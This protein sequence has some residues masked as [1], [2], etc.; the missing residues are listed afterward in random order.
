[1]DLP[2]FGL[3]GPHPHRDY[4]LNA[5]TEF[6]NAF[7]LHVGVKQ[8]VITGNSWGGLLAWYYASQHPQKVNGLIL[9]D[10]AGYKMSKIPKRFLACRYILGR[11]M[12]RHTMSKWVI[13]ADLREV[14]SDPGRLNNADVTRYVDLLLRAGNRQAFLD[15]VDKRERPNLKLLQHITS[16]TLILWGRLDN[17]YSVED[18][19]A[20]QKNIPNAVIAIIENAGHV[21]ME[22]APDVCAGHI[23]EFLETLNVG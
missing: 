3:T 20:F 19:L 16:P 12:L 14:Y 21:P 8:F 4:S 6:L 23:R 22:E 13:R 17:L 18:A 5:Y 10:A 7:A 9:V 2:G 15:F 11:W 1:V